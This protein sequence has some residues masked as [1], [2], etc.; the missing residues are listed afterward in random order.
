MPHGCSQADGT[1]GRKKPGTPEARLASALH[2][3][4]KPRTTSPSSSGLAGTP[5][6]TSSQNAR[7]RST[8]R[9]GGLPAI[10]APL[11]APMETPAI[12]SGS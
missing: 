4:K 11:M 2:S 5:S 6:V 7:R 8:R 12:Q 1:R 9:S 10:S 3:L